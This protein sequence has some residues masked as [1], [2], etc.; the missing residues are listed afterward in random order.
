MLTINSKDVADMLGKRH[1]NLLRAIRKYCITLGE[2]AEKYF[3]E[4]G[5]GRN[6][7]FKVT[8]AGC[9]LLGGRLIGKARDEFKSWYKTALDNTEPQEEVTQKLED[10]VAKAYT[11][12]EVATMLGVSERSV[13]RNIQAGKL[14]AE[15][16][17]ILV[18]TV[19]KFVTEEALEAFKAGRAN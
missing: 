9:E 6:T 5:T 10:P 14:E 8:L 18:P 11:V 12:E 3:I 1:D 16:R 15:E 4:D 19:K 13:Y 2:D 7:V 17:E